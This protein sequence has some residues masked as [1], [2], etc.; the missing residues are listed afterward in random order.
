MKLM[1]KL[2]PQLARV[3]GAESLGGGGL[4][5]MSPN[6]PLCPREQITHNAH[7]VSVIKK[8][9]RDN[10]RAALSQIQFLFEKEAK[11]DAKLKASYI[12]ELSESTWRGIARDLGISFH[13]HQKTFYQLPGDPAL[14]VAFAR[15]VL[16]ET[17]APG[18][19][20]KA[21]RKTVYG[22][23]A[24]VY[25]VPIRP[26]GWCDADGVPTYDVPVY[27][28]S[29]AFFFALTE[30]KCKIIAL[31][32]GMTSGM[33]H[34]IVDEVIGPW[35]VAEGRTILWVDAARWG[36]AGGEM[37]FILNDHG[38]SLADPPKRR[39]DMNPTEEFI[40]IAKKACWTVLNNG[41]L[42]KKANPSL[43]DIREAME[44]VEHS[45]NQS[46]TSTLFNLVRSMYDGP[47]G[48]RFHR[49][50]RSGGK[51]IC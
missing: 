25:T 48:S 36:M 26:G 7:A 33:F 1:I 46:Q 6:R 12:P 24:R 4:G 23:E 8:L 30:A 38:L 3:D 47:K 13:L 5:R 14:G 34:D 29:Q 15:R 42:K 50:I 27:V 37:R 35:A 10:P 20:E 39:P 49:L 9:V 16:R 45:I 28:P 43:L 19:L 41:V 51:P 17:K 2:R 18:A 22:D 32:C 44:V 31:D 21:A 11:K 40:A